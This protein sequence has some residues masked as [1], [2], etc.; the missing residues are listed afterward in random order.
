VHDVD[1]RH[2]LEEL[3]REMSAG[4]DAGR[5]IAQLARLRFRVCDE[6]R[7]RTGRTPGC[8]TSTYGCAAS[9]DTGAKSRS[10][11][12]GSLDLSAGLTASVVMV[13]SS[14]V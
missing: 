11:W 1:L 10:G 2:V 4:A 6:L 7:H 13:A 8:T 12:Y 9:I 3:G 5:G 14:S